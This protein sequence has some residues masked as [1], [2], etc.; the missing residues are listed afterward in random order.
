MNVWVSDDLLR[1]VK[2]KCVRNGETQKEFVV[3][4]LMAEV[5]MG[6]EVEKFVRGRAVTVREEPELAEKRRAADEA[7]A[8]LEVEEPAPICP[9]CG[10]PLIKHGG[11]WGCIPCDKV[12]EKLP[13]Q[14]KL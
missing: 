1:E 10:E 6:V 12:F 2:L 5:G 11:K 13:R 3:R 9:H 7:V 8:K 14:K 4:V